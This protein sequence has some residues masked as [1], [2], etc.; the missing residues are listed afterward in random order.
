MVAERITYLCM[1]DKGFDSKVAFAFLQEARDKTVGQ[2]QNS[3]YSLS[4]YGMR[5]FQSELRN[6]MVR[7]FTCC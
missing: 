3:V 6:M 5:S 4:L 7:Y 2:Y 1:T